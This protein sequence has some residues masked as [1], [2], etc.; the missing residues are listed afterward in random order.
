MRGADTQR[1][2]DA[3]ASWVAPSWVA[4]AGLAAVT[5]L[6]RVGAFVSP[7][8]MVID[9]GVYGVSV[10]G[11]RHGLAP[12]RGVFSAQGPLHFPLLYVG[13]LLGLRTI[14]APRVTPVIAGVIAAVAVWAIARRLSNERVAVVAGLLVATTGTMIWTTGQVTGDGPATALAVCA[15]W[16][17][18]AYRERP[19]LAR[20]VLTGV[21][22]G[23]ALA[24]KPLVIAAV[25]PVGWWLWKHRRLDHLVTAVV[26][27]GLTWLA[28]ALPWGLDLVWEQSVK[29][30]TGAGPRFSHS[31]QL[32]KLWSTLTDRDMILVVA[33]AL[34]LLATF[35]AARKLIAR[36]PGGG[37][38]DTLLVVAWTVAAMVLLVMEPAM[39]R[40]HLATIVPPLALLF[41][42]KPPPLRWFAIALIVT[43]PW[44][45]V[46]LHDILWPGDY[47]GQE[48]QV[49]D[50]LRALPAGA[51]AISDMP[52]FVWRAGMHTPRLMNDASAKRIAQKSLTTR[53]VADAAA[54]TPN[55]AVVIWSARFGDTLPGLREALAREGYRQTLRF[56]E[57]RELWVKE[58][59]RP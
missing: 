8:Q 32:R 17:A 30:N 49:V 59:C 55:C 33:V 26:V 35:L 54:T 46:H 1:R 6:L 19:A 27:A 42:L 4:V 2:V 9:D 29:F 41:A 38:E 25:I 11:M 24:V 7:R 48:K 40:N 13:D 50:A 10:I 47:R 21:L 51:Q 23:A 52:G 18:L 14:N 53:S 36:V 56:R 34:G 45:V 43:V 3:R 20:A 16:A 15:V 5:V 57:N 28:S 22:M 58:P 44:S 31:S 37:R 12:Y 39:Y